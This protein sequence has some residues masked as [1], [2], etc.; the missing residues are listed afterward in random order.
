MLAVC[1]QGP[2]MGRLTRCCIA[3][4]GCASAACACRRKSMSRGAKL[5]QHQ[6]RTRPARALPYVVCEGHQTRRCTAHWWVR[7]RGVIVW[8]CVCVCACRRARAS[9][10]VCVCVCACVCVRVRV[11]V[12]ICASVRMRVRAM[13]RT[14]HLPVDR[15]ERA[16][17]AVA[18]PDV[19]PVA[20]GRPTARPR[21][22]H[23]ARAVCVAAR[24]ARHRVGPPVAADTGLVLA[25][26]AAGA[27]FALVH[28]VEG[29]VPLR[30]ANARLVDLV[31]T[32]KSSTAERRGGARE[33]ARQRQS[34][35]ES[36]HACTGTRVRSAVQMRPRAR[37]PPTGAT[38]LARRA[39]GDER[40]RG[41]SL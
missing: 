3:G 34:A 4:S 16:V 21:A 37:A 24:P 30:A 35:T 10:C 5:G 13:A 6:E 25:R 40:M 41:A 7:T 18:R 36:K 31:R 20:V 19:A 12:C 33:R 29:V 26:A 14:S 15:H 28:V 38:R 39:Q 1:T 11:R 17:G 32:Y 9:V 2:M 22:V 27:C 8:S 23:V